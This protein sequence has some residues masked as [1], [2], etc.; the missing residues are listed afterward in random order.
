MSQ[1]TWGELK[2]RISRRSHKNLQRTVQSEDVEYW[3]KAGIEMVEQEE[4]WPWLRTTNTITLVADQY[5]YN[6][7]AALARYDAE[8]FRYGSSTSYLVDMGRPERMDFALGP[9]WRDSATTSATPE[10]FCAFGRNF[11]IGA[12]PGSTFV[13]ANPTVYFYGWKSDTYTLTQSPT[14]ATVLSIPREV[15]DCYVVAALS[16]GLQQEDDPDWARLRQTHDQNMIK[17]RGMDESID[18]NK[19]T[20]LP[21]FARHMEY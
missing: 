15:A 17:L 14:D 4:A 20:R 10:Y 21:R 2:D 5:E 18:A 16:T 1:L 9:A 8:S 11:W 7:P 19:E 13:T 3:A 12:K 6:W